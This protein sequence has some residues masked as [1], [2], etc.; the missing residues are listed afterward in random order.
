M[1]VVIYIGLLTFLDPP[2]PDTKQTIE[3][4]RLYG[5]QVTLT[6]SHILRNMCHFYNNNTCVM[7]TTEL[8]LSI[9]LLLLV[10]NIFMICIVY[11]GMLVYIYPFVTV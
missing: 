1:Y 7:L 8:L 3:N 9:E 2:R 4:A 11:V 5:V 10:F 6:L